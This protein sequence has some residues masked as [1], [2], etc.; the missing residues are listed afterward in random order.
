M[1]KKTPEQLIEEAEERNPSLEKRL[2]IKRYFKKM[3]DIFFPGKNETFYY[4]L[5][6][7]LIAVNC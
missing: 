2:K 7:E 6:F 4:F 1:L 5:G 3:L